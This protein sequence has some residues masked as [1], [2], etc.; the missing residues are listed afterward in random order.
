MLE[1]KG[2]RDEGKHRPYRVL[3]TTAAAAAPTVNSMS[4]RL[5]S[6]AQTQAAFSREGIESWQPGIFS[7]TTA[8]LEGLI[9]ERFW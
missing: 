3:I 8:L 1:R 6:D 9:S 2:W 7:S 4:Q 5:G